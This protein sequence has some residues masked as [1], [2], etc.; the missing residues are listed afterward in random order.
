MIFLIPLI[1]LF[2]IAAI[3]LWKTAFLQSLMLLHYTAIQLLQEG[4]TYT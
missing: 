3:I 2:F 4:I 1:P